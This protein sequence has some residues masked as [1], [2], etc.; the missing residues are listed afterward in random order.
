VLGS[1]TGLLDVAADEDGKSKE[2]MGAARDRDD[3]INGG[4]REKE[5]LIFVLNELK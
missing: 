4:R 2:E 3:V 5:T 1:I